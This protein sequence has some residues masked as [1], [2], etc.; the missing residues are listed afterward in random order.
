[1]TAKKKKIIGYSSGRKNGNSEVLL[2]HA[3]MAAEKQG[4]ETEI[5]QMHMAMQV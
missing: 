2:K 1:M 3:L 5:I 4:V